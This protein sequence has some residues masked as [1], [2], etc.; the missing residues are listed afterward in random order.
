M[1]MKLQF[2]SCLSSFFIVYIY[3]DWWWVWCLSV[4]NS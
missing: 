1:Q 4:D 2:G 3:K